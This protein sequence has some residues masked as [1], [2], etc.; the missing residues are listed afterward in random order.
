MINPLDATLSIGQ[1][2][3][4]TGLSVA[5]LRSWEARHG[6][7]TPHRRA[8]GH[9]RY[10]TGDAE[11]VTRV[12]G[13]TSTGLSLVDAISHREPTA[14]PAT[15]SLFA[16]LRTIR[17][18]LSPRSLRGSTL[19]AL[20]HAIEDEY[21]ARAQRGFL[22]G[23]FESERTYEAGR[24]RWDEL[25][26]MARSALVF[27][28]GPSTSAP[29]ARPGAVTRITLS[30]ESPMRREWAVVCDAPELSAAIVGWEAP[31]QQPSAGTGARVYEAIW[32]LEPLAV[33]QLA[34]LCADVAGAAG[35]AGAP[36]LTADL[37]A[38]PVPA[39]EIPVAAIALVNRFVSYIEAGHPTTPS[40][41]ADG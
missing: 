4:R 28:D 26:R 23:V 25:A 35:H 38:T 27:A 22:F 1:V 31:G 37:E 15:S 13:L 5:M 24:S 30:P 2:A 9:R 36:G 18:L 19:L 17:P 16:A 33:R 8:S 29:A 41:V 10:T 20:S 39:I 21:L 34:L 32:T 3:S 40:P 11:A 7:P 14:R 12:L 6:F